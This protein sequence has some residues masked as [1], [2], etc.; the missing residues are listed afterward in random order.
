LGNPT[1]AFVKVGVG[2]DLKK[3]VAFAR[4]RLAAMAAS[5]FK[6]ELLNDLNQAVT[7]GNASIGAAAAQLP[8]FLMGVKGANLVVK[9]A[10]IASQDMSKVKAHIVLTADQPV[11]LVTMLKATVPPFANLDI[12]AGGK[13]VKLPLPPGQ[14]PP[15]IDPYIALGKTGLGV[16]VGAGEEQM[17]SKVIDSKASSTTFLAIGYDV[18][19]AMK[20]VNDQMASMRAMMPPEAQAANQ[21]GDAMT[22]AISEIFGFTYSRVDFT[23]NGI[24]LTQTIWLK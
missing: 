4:A 23:D 2:L 19:R 16:S 13:P 12:T 22:K 11:Q 8:P 6:C 7:E 24:D 17:L 5:P 10:D 9:D 3:T 15:G 1:P 21:A 18:G 14:L 20:M